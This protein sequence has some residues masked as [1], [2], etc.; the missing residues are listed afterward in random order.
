MEELIISLGLLPYE[1]TLCCIIDAMISDYFHPRLSPYWRQIAVGGGHLIVTHAG[2]RLQLAGAQRDR[3]ADAQIDDYTGL[4]RNQFPWRPPLRLTVRAR[5]S[6]LVA[7]TAGF[8]FWN[9]PFSPFGGFPALPAAIWFFHAAPPSDMPIALDVPGYGWKAAC[10]DATG[11]GA[12]AW[13][14]LAPAVV[15][16]N[17]SPSLYRRVWPVVQRS[18]RISEASIPSVDQTWREYMLEWREQRARFMIDGAVVHETDRTSRG[19]LGFVAWVDNQWLIATPQGRLGWGLS[20]TDSQWLDL[21][22]IQIEEMKR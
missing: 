5:A 2:L 10:I 20:S 8:G 16:L 18:L 17:Q 6:A 1:D 14:P 9:N 3:Y 19:P 21:A 13:P 22:F 11:P 7:G 4:K 12:L 15:A